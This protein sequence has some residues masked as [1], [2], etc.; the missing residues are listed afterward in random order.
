ML[1]NAHDA[2]SA[3]APL[4][5][6]VD[7]TRCH[8]DRYQAPA[9]QRSREAVEQRTPTWFT[10]TGTASQTDNTSVTLIP[11]VTGSRL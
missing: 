10:A 3:W 2:D 7:A 6:E 1:S 9:N 11:A 8:S 4:A 5:A